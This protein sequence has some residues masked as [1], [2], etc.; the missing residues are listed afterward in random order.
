M[1]V[2]AFGQRVLPA[3]SEMRLLFSAKLM[4]SSLLLLAAGCLLRISSEVLAC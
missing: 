1:M 3:F 2:F 4:F